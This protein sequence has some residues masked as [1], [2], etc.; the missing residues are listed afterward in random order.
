M[1][2]TRKFTLKSYITIVC[3]C[4]VFL[5][6]TFLFAQNA[7]LPLDKWKYICVDSTRTKWGDW[8]NPKDLKYFGLS[9]ADI[10]GDGF[11]DIVSGRYFYRNPGGDLTGKWD[12]IDFGIN[13]DGML[14]ADVDGDEFG[15][16][17]AEALPDVYWIEA[18]DMQG[19]IW[20]AKKIGEIPP[21]GHV[22]GQG[23]TLAQLVAGG[24][25]EILLSSGDGIYC[26]QIPEK[27]G[28]DKWIF[29]KIA[30]KTSEEGIG[31]GDFDGDGDID[32]AAGTGEGRE[33]KTVSWWENPGN[34]EGSWPAH[35]VGKTTND[36]DRFAVADINKD[37]RMDIL[38]TE[39]GG[40][41]SVYWFTLQT[42]TPSW[43]RKYTFSMYK[44]FK[45]CRK[46][47]SCK[48]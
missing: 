23:Y 35:I 4:S 48:R 26:I 42:T 12:R 33:A 44:Q 5:S 43:R 46:M 41:S 21:A 20:N 18:Q 40:N 37:G 13:V 24:K 34:V 36:A 15:D 31:T 19:N 6:C 8:D 39:E 32:I 16:V 45:N 2:F 3:F 47:A 7:K 17:I 28:E 9:M 11:K 38:V 1:R 29:T 10:T 25:Q 27:P 30:D 22:N 14:F